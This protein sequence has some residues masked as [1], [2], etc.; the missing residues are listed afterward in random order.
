[1]SEVASGITSAVAKPVSA[2]LS[3]VFGDKVG[4]FVGNVASGNALFGPLGGAL[5]PLSARDQ[6][7][8]LARQRAEAEANEAQR[9]AFNDQVFS[10]AESFSG[11]VAQN[12]DFN[13]E[14]LTL[15]GSDPREARLAELINV[16]KTRGAS[17]QQQ[18]FQPGNSQTR[19]SLVG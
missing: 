4:G 13:F 1:M 14:A 8:E 11:R 15:A 16:F 18:E 6:E 7:K 12:P 10:L 9:K 19:L 17:V 2:V 3:P 5:A